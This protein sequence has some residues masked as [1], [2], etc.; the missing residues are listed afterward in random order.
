MEMRKLIHG[1]NRYTYPGH[2]DTHS[3]KTWIH[4]HK[5]K[6]D[7]HDPPIFNIP[8]RIYIYCPWKHINNIH[9]N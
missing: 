7:I 9:G 1:T 6:A 3:D 4:I 2:P 8:W 5:N